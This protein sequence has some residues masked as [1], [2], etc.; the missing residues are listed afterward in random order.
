MQPISVVD[1]LRRRAIEEPDRLAFAFLA[2]DG[3]IASSYTYGELDREARRVASRL[4]SVAPDGQPP[5]VILAYPP[6]L[7]FVS[8]FFGCSY[9]GMIAVPVPPLRSTRDVQRIQ[10]IAKD[11]GATVWL[12]SSS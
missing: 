9:A 4:C 7:H 2:D 8:A 1:V 11:A 5:C 10:D 12:S 3:A 6:G